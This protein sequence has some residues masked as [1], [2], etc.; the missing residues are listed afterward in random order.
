MHLYHMTNSVNIKYP[1]T[2]RTSSHVLKA[3]F[4]ISS[5]LKAYCLV[6]SAYEVII[7]CKGPFSAILYV[8]CYIENQFYVFQTAPFVVYILRSVLV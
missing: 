1:V 5:D 3:S 7:S 4:K 2:K 6:Y 8:F